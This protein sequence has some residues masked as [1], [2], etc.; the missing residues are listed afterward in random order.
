MR[1]PPR[2]ELFPSR[3][4]EIGE[5]GWGGQGRRDVTGSN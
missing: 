1:K 2:A 5:E 3:R 4:G